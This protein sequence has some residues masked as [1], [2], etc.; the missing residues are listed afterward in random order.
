MIEIW[1][2][3]LQQKD[4]DGLKDL[5]DDSVVFHSPIVHRP[6][7]GKELAFLYL[8]AA[9]HTLNNN[10]RY[11]REVIDGNNAVL[12]FLTEIEG[13]TINGVDMIKW[14]DKG[15]IIDFKVMVRPLKG[16]NMIHQKMGEM[17][18]HMQS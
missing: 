13:I 16:V 12:E 1:H 7:E 11:E 4:F 6:I 2:K 9:F 5:L 3:V 17:L 10:F 14:N 8:S 18:Q 15:K